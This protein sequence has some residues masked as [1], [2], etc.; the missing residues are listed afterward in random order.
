M[1]YGKTS[2]GLLLAGLLAGGAWVSTGSWLPDSEEV[3]A[4]KARMEA[5]EPVV[6][7]AEAQLPREIE[8]VDT[9]KATV[10]HI[11]NQSLPISREE[12]DALIAYLYA[13]SEGWLSEQ[14][15]PHFLNEVMYRL[16]REGG[17]K[18][19]IAQVFARIAKGSQVPLFRD[20][21]LQNLSHIPVEDSALR[22]AI[23]QTLTD[24]FQHDNTYAAGTALLVLARSEIEARAMGQ[25]NAEEADALAARAREL[26]KDKRVN[27]G[28][29]T[30]AVHMAMELDPHAS[31]LQV[32][33]IIEGDEPVHLRAAAIASLKHVKN[34][35]VETLLASLSKDEN[36]RIQMAALT[37]LNQ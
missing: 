17:Q 11:C 5:P 21:A 33:E 20:Y 30:A 7:L 37:A 16:A 24:G 34:D 27:L 15:T 28:T 29:R 14:P 22:A 18:R 2:L 4:V 19:K 6:S 25:G 1:Q 31:Y 10:S 13:L 9:N 32:L 26:C 23:N 3:L 36:P 35:S 8:E 12:E